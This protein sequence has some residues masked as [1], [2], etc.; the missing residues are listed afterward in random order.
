ML[1]VLLH[2]LLRAAVCRIAASAALPLD[3]TPS[4]NAPPFAT[5]FLTRLLM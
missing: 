3:Q 2:V 4:R 1:H 5:S